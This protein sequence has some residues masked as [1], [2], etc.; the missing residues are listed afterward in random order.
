MFFSKK[1]KV[2]KRKKKISLNAILWIILV[3]FTF[4]YALS[5]FG[6]I[7]TLLYQFT[8]TEESTTKKEKQTP[9]KEDT[10][11]LQSKEEKK[12]EDS[13]ST[14]NTPSNDPPP[15][16]TKDVDNI[17]TTVYFVKMNNDGLFTMIPRKRN[18]ERTNAILTNTLKELFKGPT[19]KEQNNNIKSFIPKAGLVRSIYVKDN[20]AYLDFND[21]F[22]FNSGGP[23]ASMAQLFQI[24]YTSTEFPTIDKVQILIEGK[25]VLFLSGDSG[26]AIKNPIDKIY[27]RSKL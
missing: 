18:I 10:S 1:K 3:A 20:I 21:E 15:L 14:G 6:T 23:I 2:R 17:V 7:R 4:F 25:S 5:N 26:I 22:Q 27:L 19:Q 11:S 8:S 16:S 24:V 12:N 13:F 9:I